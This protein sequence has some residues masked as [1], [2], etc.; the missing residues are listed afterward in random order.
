VCLSHA[1]CVYSCEKSPL[2]S[3]ICFTAVLTVSQTFIWNCVCDDFL[4]SITPHQ[5]VSDLTTKA[6]LYTRYWQ[7]TQNHMLSVQR[8]KSYAVSRRWPFL[9]LFLCSWLQSRV[10]NQPS[11][12]S[13]TLQHFTSVC[14]GIVSHA[15]AR[16]FTSLLILAKDRKRCFDWLINH[17][18]TL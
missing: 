18:V 8:A 12:L 16:L 14:K 13:Q 17:P 11:L 6:I 9:T 1:V 7:K 15:V 3:L 5:S 10:S 4:K 2:R